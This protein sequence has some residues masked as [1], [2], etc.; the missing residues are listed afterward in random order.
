MS[1]RDK[2]CRTLTVEGSNPTWNEQLVLQLKYVCIL[3]IDILN[4]QNFQ[5]M[6][7]YNWAYYLSRM[8]KILFCLTDKSE[9]IIQFK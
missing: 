8:G 6:H 1:Y 3:N 4:F 7:R 9:Y 5:A 2:L